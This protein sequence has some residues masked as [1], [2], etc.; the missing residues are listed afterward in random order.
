M[1]K[2]LQKKYQHEENATSTSQPDAQ[3]QQSANPFAS[4]VNGMTSY[5]GM[6][7]TQT[8]TPTTYSTSTPSY[9]TATTSYA[10]SYATTKSLDETVSYLEQ[11]NC[12]KTGIRFTSDFFPNTRKTLKES[13]FPFAA[14]IQP[15]ASV[16]SQDAFPVV[17]Y[18]AN[19]GIVRCNECRAY[20]NPFT[21]FVENGSKYRCNICNTI[22]AVPS[23]YLASLDQ[24]GE[25]VDKGE[26][27]ELCCGIYDIKAGVDYMARPPVPPT[28]I[29]LIDVSQE[30]TTT[31]M[32]NIVSNVLQDIVENELLPGGSRSQIAIMAY[33]SVLHYFLVSAKLKNPQVVSISNPKDFDGAPF[34][35]ELILN[36]KDSKASILTLLKSLPTMFANS[37]D[38]G[39][40][41][42]SAL[43]SVTKATKHIGGRLFVMQASSALTTENGLKLPAPVHT[44]D[45]KALFIPSGPEP[46]S[47]TAEMHHNF[48]SANF[49]V[50]SETYKNIITLADFARYTAGELF[51]Y[52]VS[53]ERQVKFYYELKN[54]VIK[55]TVW[56]AVFRLRVS[57]GWKITNKYGN[58]SIKSNDLLSTPSI[59]EHKSLIYELEMDEELPRAP[60]FY[61]QTALLYTNSNG[62]RRI[63]VINYGLPL[64]DRMKDV[65]A[66]ADA[67]AIAF[68]LY[69][70]ALARLYSV[71]DP[72][73]VRNELMAQASEIVREMSRECS[74]AKAG[75]YID[76]L[77]T[78]PLSILGMVKNVVLSPHGVSATK[79][80]DYRNALRIRFNSTSIDDAMLMF[81][82][83]LFALQGMVD[84]NTGIYDEEGNFVFPQLLSLTYQNLSSDGLYLIDDGMNLY[85]LVGSQLSSEILENLFGIKGS[86]ADVGKLT[87]DHMYS[88]AQHPFVERVYNLINELRLRKT[89]RYAY[90]YII[91][92]GE[93]SPEEFEFYMKLTEDKINHPLAFGMAYIEFA[94]KLHMT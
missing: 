91:K 90:L 30:A 1:H 37:K 40:C 8:S 62:E 4:P 78:F 81:T 88:N 29:F 10:T 53:E 43:D 67:Q 85:M 47:M 15:Y 24:T 68:T 25:R 36:V 51:Y 12:P 13:K 28:F 69:R 33:D 86:L 83:Y 77:A 46:S 17:Q 92:E 94:N 27:V 20:V 6:T 82:P 16:Y 74:I 65:Y 61:A 52:P 44:L 14:V 41:L 60:V 70:K 57:A 11:Y 26:R 21:K 93:K 7:T 55:D 2:A 72:T 38:R 35:D 64:V 84:E 31:G 34:P 23:Y 42:V 79:E 9:S 63:R 50:F 19:Q 5:G 73:T 45:K 49:F 18:G 48:I 80:M 71:Q 3:A 56:E 54:T 66:K 32:L 58:Y 89:E 22:N 76:S 87:E 75:T 59:D 39:S